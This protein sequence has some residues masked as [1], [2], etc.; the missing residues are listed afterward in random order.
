MSLY[1]FIEKKIF[2]LED[3]N[4]HTKLNAYFI[5]N[6]LQSNL[7]SSFD[8]S[9]YFENFFDSKLTTLT[10]EPETIVIWGGVN[11][12]QIL[13]IKNILSGV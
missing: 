1:S 12:K 13:K 8:F 11:K 6:D 9:Q 5:G 2:R 3:F 4:G 10:P 7:F